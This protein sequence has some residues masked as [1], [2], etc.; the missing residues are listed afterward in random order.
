MLV[1]GVVRSAP[2]GLLCTLSSI[3]RGAK[4]ASVAIDRVYVIESDSGIATGLSL[5]LAKALSS[6]FTYV[7]LGDLRQKIPRR[8]ARLAFCRNEYLE[9]VQLNYQKFDMVVVADFDFLFPR[10]RFPRGLAQFESSNKDGILAN[11]L[12]FYYDI[13]AFEPKSDLE[14]MLVREGTRLQ[15][16]IS[17]AESQ[18]RI[19]KRP[20]PFRVDAAFG[21]LAVYKTDSIYGR[22]YEVSNQG[23]AECEHVSFSKRPTQL[24]LWVDDELSISA[25][26]RHVFV[27]ALLWISRRIR[28]V[29]K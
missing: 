27:A 22:Q 15:R 4:R 9:Y 18:L 1:T 21:G 2:L 5:R 17:I 14:P 20:K 11:S 28:M 25:P 24:N 3:L 12:P 8:E 19:A 23:P 26:W 10:V 16:A 7:R 13:Y 29:T 6:R